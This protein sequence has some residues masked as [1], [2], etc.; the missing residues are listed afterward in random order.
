MKKDESIDF[1]NIRYG[2]FRERR[3]IRELEL[4][5]IRSG[6][7]VSEVKYNMKARV[8]EGSFCCGN[9]LAHIVNNHILIDDH[10]NSFNLTV[11]FSR[12]RLKI[13]RNDGY[14]LT[15]TWDKHINAQF[16][17]KVYYKK[18]GYS[19]EINISRNQT[20]LDF[21]KIII[22]LLSFGLYTPNFKGILSK[23][24]HELSQI[25]QEMLFYCAILLQIFYLPF[26][27]VD[28]T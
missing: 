22:G 25:E 27:Y 7:S 23:R 13:I 17:R 16:M 5:D 19:Y 11:N 24:C 3:G 21:F 2:F 9:F 6:G 20:P 1:L 15:V 12:Q 8:I 10:S 4:I 28:W 14:E 18:N 26:D